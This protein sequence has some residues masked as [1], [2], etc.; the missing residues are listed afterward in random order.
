[1]NPDLLRSKLADKN[2]RIAAAEAALRPPAVSLTREALRRMP[3]GTAAAELDRVEEPLQAALRAPAACGDEIPEAAWQAALDGALPVL[4]LYLEGGYLDE[5]LSSVLEG[6]PLQDGGSLLDASSRQ[7]C[8][9]SPGGRQ[10]GRA[11]P[12]GDG[13]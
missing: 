3:Q 2:R 7:A 11:A 4:D 5:R 12:S 1:M 6:G 9:P 13:A 8:W 10:A